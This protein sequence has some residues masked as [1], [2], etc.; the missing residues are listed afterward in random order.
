MAKS[1][2]RFAETDVSVMKRMNS[3]EEHLLKLGE[4]SG[5]LRSQKVYSGSSVTAIHFTLSNPRLGVMDYLL[6]PQIEEVN[7]ILLGQYKRSPDKAK[8]R[9]Q[10]ERTA[11]ALVEQWLSIQVD[12]I[13]LGIVSAE[14]AF[15]H[16]LYDAKRD[17]TMGQLFEQQGAKMLGM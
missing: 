6:R 10:A 2:I 3:I 16:S 17:V 13:R 7:K 8:V 5:L 4:T 15:M 11:W 1:N 9:A 14:A 12:L